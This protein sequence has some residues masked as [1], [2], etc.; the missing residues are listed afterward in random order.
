M[1]VYVTKRLMQ[2]TFHAQKILTFTAPLV[3]I[4]DSTDSY[5]ARPRPL[6]YYDAVAVSVIALCVQTGERCR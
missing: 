1:L 6:R 3:L 5:Q 2:T 4:W